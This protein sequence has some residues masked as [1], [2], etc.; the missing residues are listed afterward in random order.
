MQI[1]IDTDP[2]GPLK[3]LDEL[4]DEPLTVLEGLNGIG[5]TLAIRVLQLCTGTF[6]YASRDSPAWKSLCEGLGEFTIT[7]SGLKGQFHEIRWT[8]HSHDWGE[9]TTAPDYFRSVTI[10]G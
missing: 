3:V 2:P 10:D 7:V 9:P 1:H 5:K 6:P 8:G 4:P